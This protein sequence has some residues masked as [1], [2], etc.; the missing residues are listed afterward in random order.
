M[1]S[2]AAVRIA[3]VGGS[4]VTDRS[5]WGKGFADCF[6]EA[7]ELLN[8]AVDGRR[9]KRWYEEWAPAHEPRGQAEFCTD[10]VWSQRRELSALFAALRRRASRD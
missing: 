8:F 9:S 1:P 10:P 5:G 2:L 4:T 6:T 7:G 3:L